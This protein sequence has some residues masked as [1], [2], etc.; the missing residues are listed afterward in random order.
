[1]VFGVFARP[2][3]CH[4]HITELIAVTLTSVTSGNCGLLHVYLH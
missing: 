1:M 2:H 4:A 3:L